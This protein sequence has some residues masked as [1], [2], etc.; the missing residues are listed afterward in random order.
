MIRLLYH[1]SPKQKLPNSKNEQQGAADLLLY[2]D[3][4]AGYYWTLG[5]TKGFIR[6]HKLTKKCYKSFEQADKDLG[7][8]E[9]LKGCL[10]LVQETKLF[11]AATSPADLCAGLGRCCCISL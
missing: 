4:L 5:K 10:K 11:F 2:G 1:Y 8:N 3:F 6:V 9:V 7:N